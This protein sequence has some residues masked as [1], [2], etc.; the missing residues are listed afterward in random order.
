MPTIQIRINCDN[1]SF[2]VNPNEIPNILRELAKD[3]GLVDIWYVEQ[4]LKDAFL[5]MDEKKIKDSNGNTVGF[6]SIYE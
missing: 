5:D 4:V 2:F 6:I 1:D 3:P